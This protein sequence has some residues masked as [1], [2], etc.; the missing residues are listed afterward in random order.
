MKNIVVQKYGGTSLATPDHFLRVARN[1]K[2]TRDSG[3]HVA[4]VVSAMAGETD[5]LLSLLAQLGDAPPARETDALLATGE[6]VSAALMAAAL[7]KKG[8]P[9]RSFWG[10]QIPL[11]TD[12]V[13][14]RARILDLK[15]AKLK[16]TLKQGKVAVIAGFQGVNRSGDITTLGRGGSD[17]TAVAVAAALKAGLCEIYTDVDGIYTTDPGIYSRARRLDKITYEE[18]LE[19]SGLGARV[20]Q[21]RSVELAR[22]YYV[23]LVVK[24]SFGGEQGTWIVREEEVDMESAAVSG[25]TLDRNEG[26]LTVIRVPDRPGIAHAIISPLADAAVNV[27]MIIQNVSSD[28]FTDFSFTVP[29]ADLDLARGIV[30][31]VAARIGVRE[32]RVDNSIAKV[33]VVGIGMK[34]HPGVAARMF[35]VLAGENIN[36]QMIS[37]SEIR[38]SCVVDSKY[39]EL[40]V[41]ALHDA[42]E[43]DRKK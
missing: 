33:S 11:Y 6:Q 14:T 8:C 1:I 15:A 20:L 23:P 16:R 4:V 35:E 30:E 26:K 9:S 37:T 43:L 5:R 42:F 40:A 21:I 7:E 32:V 27:D 29:L 38:I 13:H 17:T 10:I 24:S 18:M 22:K 28:G 36:I 31:E 2:K 3:S 39:G 41:R 25:I 34:N 12:S 19:M